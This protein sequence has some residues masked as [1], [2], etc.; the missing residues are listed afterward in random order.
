MTVKIPSKLVEKKMKICKKI[1]NDFISFRKSYDRLKRKRIE[2]VTEHFRKQTTT[3]LDG[4]YKVSIGKFS[5]I[6]SK[7]YCL[8]ILDKFC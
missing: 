1:V 5:Y 7:F 8:K 3:V 2:K 4:Q 6:M